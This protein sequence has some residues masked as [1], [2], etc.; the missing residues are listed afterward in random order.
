MILR[1]SQQPDSPHS[2][3]FRKAGQK[4]AEPNRPNVVLPVPVWPCVHARKQAAFAVHG[5]KP[6]LVR[7]VVVPRSAASRRFHQPKFLRNKGYQSRVA[8]GQ[9]RRN[10][11]RI[12]GAPTAPINQNQGGGGGPPAAGRTRTPAGAPRDSDAPPGSG[13]PGAPPTVSPTHSTGPQY[14][15]DANPPPLFLSGTRTCRKAH[16]RRA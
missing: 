11:N 3:I 14:D 12:T 16:P 9:T 2:Q 15:A 4:K 10:P 7:R 1:F 8:N 5:Q 13:T 6:A